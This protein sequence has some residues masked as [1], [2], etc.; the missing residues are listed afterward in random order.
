M[1]NLN[2]PLG[3]VWR[4]W[5]LHIHSNASD[6]KMTPD[7]II[8][9]AIS[10]DIDVIAITDH[11]TARNVDDMIKIGN[12]KGIVVIPGVEFRTEYGNKS[13]H[14]IGLF[15]YK[16]NGY[17]MD[18]NG[19]YD[20]ILSPLG[21]TEN[22]IKIAGRKG[23]S[24]EL[25]DE[26]AFSEGLCRVQVDFRAAANKIHEYGG[27]VTVHAGSKTNSFDDEMK[28]EGKQS[29][30][31]SDL[32]ESLG[33]VKEDLMTGG[34]IDI[35]EIRKKKDSEEFYWE[36]FG[37][38]SIIASDAHKLDEI[39]RQFSWIKADMTIE[40]LKQA[41]LEK[42]RFYLGDEPGVIK[43]VNSNP[44]K[45]IKGIIINKNEGYTNENQKWFDNVQ[46][47]FNSELVSII[48]NKGSGKS[49]IA[50]I[51]GLLLNS[52]HS[53]DFQFLEKDR[54]LKKGFAE[55]FNASL[56][57]C[58]G[59]MI[60]DVILSQKVKPDEPIKVKYLPQHY[61]ETLCNEIGKVNKFREEVESV[62]YQYLSESDK[63]GKNSF[64]D[65]VDF[66]MV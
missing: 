16:Y 11:H 36:T 49:A 40:G 44:T 60:S 17:I 38:V 24:K 25:E 57:L 27:L 53:E 62:V 8:N 9:K 43:R 19:I 47:P 23:T 6:G 64:K 50:D 45:Y 2:S 54:F 31:V 61:F 5:D 13:V 21:L 41:I 39:G 18:S 30:N 14:M 32:Y 33:T 58:S 22:A 15:P 48:G 3:S 34:F 26:K 37:K 56:E 20:E 65:L 29:K 52:N 35:C 46:I 10:L 51:L 42:D 12:E 4:K 55:N 63:L 28:H 1:N 66:R 7:E 59:H